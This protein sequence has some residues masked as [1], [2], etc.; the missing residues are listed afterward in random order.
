MLSSKCL[1]KEFWKFSKICDVKFPYQNKQKSYFYRM[2]AFIDHAGSLREVVHTVVEAMAG[3]G[4]STFRCGKPI[5]VH[6][7]K[8]IRRQ[9]FY[10]LERSSH[11]W[12]RL[13]L[14]EQGREC[15]S[16]RRSF[17]GGRLDEIGW[18]PR[19]SI[20]I[21]RDIRTGKRNPIIEAFRCGSI[22]PL[23]DQAACQPALNIAICSRCKAQS[24]VSF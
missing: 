4:G 11:W 8:S 3:F 12:I 9:V 17:T 22:A 5:I 2:N 14:G 18:L 16:T 6:G 1:S 20:N 24:T 13:S 10:F 21:Y 15:F 19:A 7:V 23:I